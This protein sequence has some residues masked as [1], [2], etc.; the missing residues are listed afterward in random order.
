MT[1]ILYH[2]CESDQESQQTPFHSRHSTHQIYSEDLSS[3]FDPFC[4]LFEVIGLFVCFFCG[5]SFVFAGVLLGD[6]VL[7]FICRSLCCCFC[8]SLR[9]ISR[10]AFFQDWLFLRRL[11][12]LIV[13]WCV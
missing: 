5:L 6:D 12:T 2:Y 9:I 8:Q 4:S 7:L 11:L 1:K 3:F 13:R 10:V